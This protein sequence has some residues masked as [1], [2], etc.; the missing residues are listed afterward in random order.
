LHQE[1]VTFS[2]GIPGENLVKQHDIIWDISPVPSDP[3]A[4]DRVLGNKAAKLAIPIEQ[5]A[6]TMAEEKMKQGK[7]K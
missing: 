7:N 6:Q 1:E 3:T 5:D 4:L 2:G